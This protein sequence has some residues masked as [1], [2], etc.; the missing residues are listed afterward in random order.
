MVEQQAKFAELHFLQLPDDV[1]SE[2]SGAIEVADEAL[3]RARVLHLE[4]LIFKTIVKSRSPGKRITELISGFVVDMH[5]EPFEFIG[6]VVRD[7]LVNKRLLS[8]PS[9]D[10]VPL[11]D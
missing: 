7:Y 5:T 4:V 11:A 8:K 1:K 10:T 3:L 2:M 6:I 9:T